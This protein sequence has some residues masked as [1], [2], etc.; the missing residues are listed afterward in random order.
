MRR[1]ASNATLDR[2]AFGAVAVSILVI[3]WNGLRAGGGAVANA[4]L[5][6]AFLTVAMRTV[7]LR[8][9]V[10]LPPWLFAAAIGFALAAML[11]VIFP[12][13]S[14]TLNEILLHYR[15]IPVA[16]GAQPNIFVPRSDLPALIQFEVA[17]LVIPLLVASVADTPRRIERL[18]DVFVLGAAINAGVGLVDWAGFH[19]API[20]AG[21]GRSAGLTIHPN[22]LALTCTVAI[23]LALLWIGRGGR[24]RTAGF[25][26]T[27]LLLAG[28]YASGSRV[29]AV[30]AL[31]GVLA[32]VIVVP[33]LRTGLGWT[34]PAVG[35]VLLALVFFAGDQILEQI[36]ISGDVGT[37]VNTAGSDSQR[38]QLAQLAIDQ[39]QARPLSGVGFSVIADAHSIYLQLLAAGGVIAMLSFL[40]YLGGLA[41]S[42]WRAMAGPLRDVAAAAGIS[43]VMWLINGFIDNQLGDKYLF[44]IPGLLIALSYVA[45]TRAPESRRPLPVSGQ[46]PTS[47]SLAPAPVAGSA[48]G[49]EPAWAPR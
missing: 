49:S 31:L 7:V 24:W 18:L 1:S 43:I 6:P 23:P 41:A 46:T 8:K 12:P 32:T 17:L 48:G 35:I 36:R 47:R 29:G 21:A 14:S 11:R 27:G 25:G 5:V 44:V 13:D 37:A 9:P 28:A 20:V 30:T 40:T 10:P 4:F 22:Y 45:A 39:F 33:S 26:C 15:T 16:G 38:S 3:T 42:V 19:V 34:V 2:L